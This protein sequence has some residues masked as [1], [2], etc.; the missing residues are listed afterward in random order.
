MPETTLP[1]KEME[2]RWDECLFELSCTM[3][4][5]TF[6][7]WLAGSRLLALDGDSL[8][9]GVVRAAAAEWLEHTFLPACRGTLGRHFPGLAAVHVLPLAGASHGGGNGTGEAGATPP[10]VGAAQPAAGEEDEAVECDAVTDPALARF[11]VSLAGWSKLAN[12]AMDYWSELLGP[13]AFQTWLA[14]RHEDMRRTK[15]EWTPPM[16]FSV[17]H[18]ARKAAKGDRRNITGVWR[19]C[20]AASMRQRGEPCAHCA[21]RGGQIEA[22]HSCRYWS[23]G[24]LDRLQAEGVAIVERRGEGLRVTYRVR[25]FTLLPLLT[26][27]QVA[28]LHPTTQEAHSRWLLRQG[29][30]PASWERLTVRHLALPPL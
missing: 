8:T 27:A 4:P 11:D 29:L 26:P 6:N 23:P 7:T 18:L 9:V 3:T 25:V 5:A 12:Y 22:P 2:R 21:E 16:T 20:R 10:A 30:D 24:A 19:A 28:G 14:I 15:T 13:T 17:S 1:A